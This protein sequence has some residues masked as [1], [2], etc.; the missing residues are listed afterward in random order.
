MSE[1]RVSKVVADVLMRENVSRVFGIPGSHILSVFDTLV[2]APIRVV[3]AATETSAAYM[4]GMHGYLTGKAGVTLVTA[5]PG[6]VS[7]LGGVAQAF[8]S[9]F[10]LVHISGD[11]PVRSAREAFHG[12]DVADFLHRMFVPVTKRAFRLERPEDTESVLHEAFR[13]AASGR[14]GP[15]HVSIPV[16]LAQQR[17]ASSG[18]VSLRPSTSQA[19]SP[20]FISHVSDRL[21]R[22]KRAVIVACRGALGD[23]GAR[24]ATLAER[25]SAPV[26]TT[27]YGLGAIDSEHPLALGTFSE[28]SKNTFAFAQVSSADFVLVLGMRAQTA[29]SSVLA[30]AIHCESAFLAYEDDAWSPSGM[31]WRG[32]VE[33]GSARGAVEALLE[34]VPQKPH[35]QA[36]TRQI[37]DD[38]R[39]FERGLARAMAPHAAARPL[40]FG[41]ALGALREVL[42]ED[43]MVVSGVGHHH[44]WAR[45]VLP[46]R[47]RTAFMAEA[48]WGTMGGELGG[49]IAA[50]LLHPERQ[51]V[52]VTG[53]G[54]LLMVLGD[55][56]SAVQERANVL[57]VV[58]N[59]SR[60]GIIGQMQRHTFGRTIADGIP[61]V[62]FAAA[63]RSMG[64]IGIRLEDPAEIDETVRAA[65][66]A[67]AAGP[68]LLDVVSQ[69]D[70]AW[71]TRDGLVAA[72]RGDPKGDEA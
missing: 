29:M 8:A 16:D 59:D 4:A 64:G 67:T 54:S 22:A 71:P 20:A 57:V 25:V 40:H 18:P 17:I 52:V 2:D 27:A 34:A 63:A 48:S 53:D 36:W 11:V 61:R 26:L 44:V 9:S 31:H 69:S 30:E 58:L 62:D 42:Q 3:T 38:R 51:V 66:A 10:P 49:G 72:G 7:S 65:L 70:V 24:I 56:A 60:H 33:V 12:T 23:G 32:L 37:D 41:R 5:G 1:R 55:F 50:K 14:P 21:T 13:I 35:D 39:A 15:V 28:F 45:N 46:A 47:N 19:A 68:V 43:A 6:A